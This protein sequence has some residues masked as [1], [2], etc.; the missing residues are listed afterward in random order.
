MVSK[1]DGYNYIVRLE[2]GER[3]TEALAQFFANSDTQVQGA[4]VSGVGAAERL[5]LG[6]YDLDA[7]EYIWRDFDPLYE[8]TNLQGAIAA[9]EQGDLAFHL[10]GTFSD[11]N[12]QV[13]GGHVK[14]FVVGGTCELFIHV[15][16]QPLKRKH[17]DQTG[18]NLL[19]L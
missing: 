18:L 5:T 1:F 3:L 2:R 13:I 14:D 15:T 6:F 7:K 12:Y 19:D 8:I 10:H 4:S 9:D 17:D 16:Y 11:R